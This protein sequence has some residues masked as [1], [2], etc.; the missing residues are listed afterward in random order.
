MPISDMMEGP[1]QGAFVYFSQSGFYH[2]RL[3]E[4]CR[5]YYR[6]VPIPFMTLE[7]PF[8]LYIAREVSLTSRIKDVIILSVYPSRDYFLFVPA[9]IFFLKILGRNKLQ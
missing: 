2:K 6:L 4:V 3:W 5:T 9:N 8:Y 7:E 1:P